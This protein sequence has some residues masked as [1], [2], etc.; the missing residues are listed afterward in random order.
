MQNIAFKHKIQKSLRRKLLLPL[1]FVGIIFTAG[2]IL[3][4]QIRFQQ[5]LVEKLAV[6]AE[7]LA[8]TVNYAAEGLSRAGELQR[9]VTTLGAE[10][11]VNLILVIVGTQPARIVAANKT[12]FLGKTLDQVINQDKDIE[13]HV[14]A[15]LQ[16]K[17]KATHFDNVQDTYEIAI[18]LLISQKAI[19]SEN[20]LIN[21]AVFVQL[22]SKTTKIDALRTIVQFTAL[23]LSV[24]SILILYSY[25]LL[26]YYVIK[27]VTKIISQIS[28]GEPIQSKKRLEKEYDEI[29]LLGDCLNDAFIKLASQQKDLRESEFRWKFALEGAG[30]GLW[31]WDIKN[32][33]VFFSKRWKEM[34]GFDVDEIKNDFEEWAS[35][36][37]RDDKAAVFVTVQDYLNEKTSVYLCEHRLLCKDGNYKWILARGTVVDRDQDG[38]AARIIGTH[39]DIDKRK[40]DEEQLKKSEARFRSIIDISPVPLA[41]NDNLHNITFLNNAFTN[42]FGYDLNDIPTLSQWWEKAYPDKNYRQW[43]LDT[44]ANTIQQCERENKTFSPMEFTIC[45]KDGTQKTV[46]ASATGISDSFDLHLVVLYDITERKQVEKALLESEFRWK[47]AVEGSGDGL[48]D[49]DIKNSTVFFSHRWKEMLG[50]SDNDIGNGLDEWEKRIH[51]DEKTEVF[52]TVA[53]Y[54]EGKTKIYI[55][56]HRV[57]CKDGS[58]KWILDRGVIVQRDDEGKPLRMIG[59]HT[60]ITERK[61]LE[62]ELKRS[63][64]ELEQFAYAVSHD[65]RQPLRMVT[66]YLDLI[67]KALEKQLD[68]ETRQFLTFAIDGAKR[69]DSMILS[70][71]DY[72]RMGRKTHAVELISSRS[73]A[74]EALLFL[75]PALEISGGSIEISGDWVDLMANRDELTRLFQNL[76]GNA[77]KYHNENKP[78][79][80]K[81]SATVKSNTFRVEVRDNGIGINPSQ[82]DR[83]F[84]VFSRLQTRSRFEGTGVGLALCRKIVE[85]HG[86][87]IGVE[88]AGEELGCVFWFELPIIE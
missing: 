15:A 9:I 52:K 36:I 30:D 60:D 76:I 37:H 4:A 27:P 16:S 24:F 84:K 33:T 2:V 41:L 19:L 13:N 75:Q 3:L 18:P 44:W 73:A 34:L 86:G 51:P 21:A 80:V 17:E 14:Q 28:N 47:F 66:S 31:D 25:G 85:H 53:D 23:F 7:L 65:M 22:D 32:S 12:A 8:N 83:L 67:E 69:M 10:R 74:D 70:L 1:I 26:R 71:L 81:I 48:W 45:C 63:N 38:S 20:T 61:N 42:T 56:E 62:T 87:T 82:I 6:R 55:C 11:D 79:V 88:S 29:S 50:F 46:L 49:W 57:S 54:L 68:D 78:P 5:L 39:T 40:H 72:S 64:A 58:Y 35:R 43:V 59:T 77:L